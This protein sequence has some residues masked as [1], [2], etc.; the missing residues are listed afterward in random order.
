MTGVDLGAGNLAIAV[1]AAVAGSYL[2]GAV[3]FSYLIPRLIHGVDIRRH[4]S[5]NVGATNV[6]RVLGKGPGILCFALDMAKG[7]VP[8]ALAQATPGMPS[9]LPVVAA[10]AAIVGHSKSV[11]LG[12]GGGKAVATGV[13]TILALNPLVGLACLVVWA[14]VFSLTKVVSIASI[15]A[16]LVLPGFMMA[17]PHP[18]RGGQNPEI[19]IYFAIAAGAFVILRHRDNIRRIMAGTESRFGS[20]QAA[21]EREEDPTA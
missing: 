7:M 10:A 6:A 4:G 8:V 18:F 14:I 15:T 2:L 11:F 21:P 20:S 9:W 17:I 16:A 5:G 12:M 13:G 19:Y 1:T 3:P